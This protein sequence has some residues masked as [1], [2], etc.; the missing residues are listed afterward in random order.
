MNNDLVTRDGDERLSLGYSES[1]ATLYLIF[2][3]LLVK[4]FQFCD[5]SIQG[6]VLQFRL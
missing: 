4:I 2:V 6:V 3:T 5:F 1:S